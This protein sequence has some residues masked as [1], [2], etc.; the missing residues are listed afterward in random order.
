VTPSELLS[1]STLTFGVDSVSIVDLDFGQML[2]SQADAG[3]C[4]LVVKG[5]FGGALRGFRY[6]GNGMFQ[7]DR[8]SEPQLFWQTLVEAAGAGSEL[9]FTGVPIG[10]GRRI[11]IDSDGDGTLDGDE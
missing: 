4:D 9:T 7:S 5:V 1:K 3:N 6:V 2:V 10:S 8:Q 11:G